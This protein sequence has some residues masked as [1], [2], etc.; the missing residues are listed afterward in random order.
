MWA[1]II[2]SVRP[3][4][5]VKEFTSV[6]MILR[7]TLNMQII[8]GILI[9]ESPE[10]IIDRSSV[11]T[12]SMIHCYNNVGH[13]ETKLRHQSSSFTDPLA[14]L[15]NTIIHADYNVVPLFGHQTWLEGVGGGYRILDI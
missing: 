5:E 15:T 14:I 1:Y 8:L 7:N 10:R 2:H 3:T 11:L 12:V 6:N 9:Q 13:W 4:L